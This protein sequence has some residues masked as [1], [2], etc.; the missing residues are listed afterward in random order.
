MKKVKNTKKLGVAMLSLVAAISIGA[1]AIS[2]ASY[3][4]ANAATNVTYDK[5]KDPDSLAARF[6]IGEKVEMEAGYIAPSYMMAEATANSGVYFNFTEENSFVTVKKTYKPN[7]LEKLLSFIPIVDQSKVGT[8]ADIENFTVII[9]DSASP[10]KKITFTSHN[11]DSNWIKSNY[12][13]LTVA[14]SYEQLAFEKNE[15][16]T[17]KLD[18]DGNPIPIYV[19]D[20]DGNPTTTQAKEVVSQIPAGLTHSGATNVSSTGENPIMRKDHGKLITS[21]YAG[22]K[23]GTKAINLGYIQNGTDVKATATP[24]QN[25]STDT[26]VLRDFKQEVFYVHDATHEGRGGGSDEEWEKLQ[27]GSAIDKDFTFEGFNSNANLKIKFGVTKGSGAI[28]VSNLCGEDISNPIKA[29]KTFKG[30]A[31]LNY[32]IPAP[33]FYE[34]NKAGEGFTNGDLTYVLTDKDGKVIDTN[35]TSVE[36]DANSAQIATTLTS[37]SVYNFKT[38]GVYTMTYTYIY[39]GASGKEKYVGKYEIEV[40]PK[41]EFATVDIAYASEMDGISR[42][43]ATVGM[44]FDIGAT[45]TSYIYNIVD[46]SK[47]KLEILVDNAPLATFDNLEANKLYQFNKAGVYTFNYYAID[48]VFNATSEALTCLYTKTVVISNNYHALEVPAKTSLSEGDALNNLK[49]D[50]NIVKFYDSAKLSGLTNGEIYMAV[51][52]PGATEFA[53]L[54]DTQKENGYNFAKGVYG[55]YEFIYLAEYTVNSEQRSVPEQLEESDNI[56]KI[57][58]KYYYSF[59]VTVCDTSS[60]TIYLVGEDYLTGATK[61]SS[62]AN[63]HTYQ[64]IKGTK[65][66]FAKLQALDFIGSTS[67]Y[68]DQIALTVTKDGTVLGAET[69]TYASNRNAYSYTFAS[70]GQYIFKFTVTDGSSEDTISLI[71]DVEEEFYSISSNVEFKDLYS[72]ADLINVNSFDVVTSKGA[73][74]SNATKQFIVTKDGETVYT[75]NVL[76][77]NPQNAGEYQIDFVAKIGSNEVAK[78]SFTISV[79]D[80]SAPVI[81]VKGK[82]IKSALLGEEIEIASMVAKDND[83][84]DSILVNSISITFNG[85]EVNA[86]RGKLNPTEVGVYT[87]KLTSTDTKGNVSTYVYE[88]EIIDGAKLNEGKVI[89]VDV[90]ALILGAVGI[91]LVV[92]TLV[93]LFAVVLKKPKTVEVA[94]TTDVADTTTTT[95]ETN[96]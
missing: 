88:I 74:A 64:V 89:G 50:K 32:T 80:K 33:K 95:D 10:D 59:T 90:W 57:G 34:Y 67:D 14:Y 16:G 94:D 61:I 69:A 38:E 81:E 78:K 31:G 48:D 70:A 2:A 26:D 51:K 93:V 30:F 87:V 18:K 76:N 53:E 85:K 47:I 91:V 75:N 7:E 39:N 25:A 15:D 19:L 84:T 79:E 77:F 52:V 73:I 62:N 86:F 17:N 56:K 20:K 65:V 9:Y 22:S 66:E 60:P 96:E 68:S 35:D 36:K 54:T 29:G 63:A 12:S 37:G 44:I 46:E 3:G 40:M 13:G 41:D 8:S 24:R 27:S 23:S 11:Y 43:N 42:R 92:T 6:T 4:I 45:S 5:V 58:D 49:I 21:G 71:V 1:T 82:V 83:D 55:D 28:L 72:T